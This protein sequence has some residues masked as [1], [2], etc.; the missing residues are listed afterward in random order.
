M[1]VNGNPMQNFKSDKISAVCVKFQN[2]IGQL[3]YG[4]TNSTNAI[5]TRLQTLLRE[6]S[7]SEDIEHWNWLDNN[8]VEYLLRMLAEHENNEGFRV[9]YPPSGAVVSKAEQVEWTELLRHLG[10]DTQRLELHNLLLAYQKQ[11]FARCR[12]YH[13]ACSVEVDDNLYES[14][15]TVFK[16]TFPS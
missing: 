5:V 9:I 12:D 7:P 8:N 15:Y 2:D 1:E 11:R 10:S 16:A 6:L 14:P 3:L 13:E 4:R